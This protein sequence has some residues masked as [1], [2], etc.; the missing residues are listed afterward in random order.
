MKISLILKT[1]AKLR[2]L[3]LCKEST[4][5][6]FILPVLKIDLFF[7]HQHLKRMANIST[8]HKNLK[9]PLY[10]R[11]V[12]LQ[13]NKITRSHFFIV[14]LIHYKHKIYSFNESALMQ[15]FL[16]DCP[17][18]I[19]QQ[20]VTQCFNFINHLKK[21]CQSLLLSTPD[22]CSYVTF[23]KDHDL[24]THLIQVVCSFEFKFL[25]CKSM[26]YH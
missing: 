1:T 5:N 3:Y 15:V 19:I 12:F 25:Y 23:Q 26:L 11:G 6:I 24:R 9:W 2:K 21:A 17:G 22:S 14:L 10:T 8:T 18:Q 7:S 20:I 16:S 4:K 13:L